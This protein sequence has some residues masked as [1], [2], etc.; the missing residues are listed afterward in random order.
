LKIDDPNRILDLLDWGWFRNAADYSACCQNNSLSD[1]A[2]LGG[3]LPASF[4]M[5]HTA[6]IGSWH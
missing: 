2:E 5:A 1:L 6:S 4:G 3:A